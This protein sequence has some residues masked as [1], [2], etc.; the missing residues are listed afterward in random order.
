MSDT[1]TR[2]APD[3]TTLL[4]RTWSATGDPRGTVVIQHGLAEHSGRYEHVG[5]H[6]A[7][8]GFD[9]IAEDARG[10]GE[11][12]GARTDIDHYDTFLDDLE[13]PVGDAP[14]PVILYGHSFGGL[15]ATVYML[16]DRPKPDLLVLSAPFFDAKVPI[17]KR[18]AAHLLPRVLPKI[19]IPLGLKKDQLS[20]DPAVGEAYFAD[21]LVSTNATVR[22]GGEFVTM[23]ERVTKELTG[24]GIPTLVIHGGSDPIVPPEL[25]VPLADMPGVERHLFPA[26]RHES[27]NEEDGVETLRVIT[28]WL[29]R[30]LT[31]S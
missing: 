7:A 20:R 18:A 10:H 28:E 21:P 11:S 14:G 16:E 29:D 17:Y 31:A 9:V 26:Y 2:T 30:Q 24:F 25:T 12:G 5:S 4:R 6:L 15:L 3:G 19:R 8:A 22:L 27:H 1:Q 13:V 23:Q